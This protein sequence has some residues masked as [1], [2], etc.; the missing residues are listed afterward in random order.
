M[1]T[2]IAA[3]DEPLFLVRKIV[4]IKGDG[5][6]LDPYTIFNNFYPKI[7]AI[8]S[9]FFS[10]GMIAY[11]YVTYPDAVEVPDFAR[12]TLIQFIGLL[13]LFIGSG[14]LF[15]CFLA[16]LTCS[17]LCFGDLDKIGE[18]FETMDYDE[19]VEKG[20]EEL[21][22][23]KKRYKQ[24]ATSLDFYKSSLNIGNDEILSDGLKPDDEEVEQLDQEIK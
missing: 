17:G 22:E 11:S 10:I 15:F 13:C 2:Y 12:A 24:L 4:E 21:E 6:K 20:K 7:Y 18:G 8:S 14:I 3:G 9:V 23:D 16:P 1:K 5:I 19:I